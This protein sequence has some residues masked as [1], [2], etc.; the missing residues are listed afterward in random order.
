V[1]VIEAI[2]TRSSIRS[3]KPDRISESDMNTLM[4]AVRRTQSWANTQC[5]EVVLVTDMAVKEK[6]QM[7]ISKGNPSTKGMV[8]A[9]VVVVFCAKN[10]A[11]GYYKEK[12]TTNK[13]DWYMFDVGLAVENFCL[14]AHSLGLGTVTVG[15]FDAEAVEKILG[16]PEGYSVVCINPLGYPTKPSSSPKRKEISDFIHYNKF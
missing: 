15:V 11:S 6:L 4:E 3:F 1:D 10:K 16:I 12:A 2:Q 8:G 5:W 7:T 9:P 14:A 13:G